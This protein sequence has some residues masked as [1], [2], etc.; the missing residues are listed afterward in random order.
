MTHKLWLVSLQSNLTFLVRKEA[1]VLPIFRWLVA[2]TEF[3][4][5]YFSYFRWAQLA[6]VSFQMKFSYLVRVLVGRMSAKRNRVAE[7]GALERVLSQARKSRTFENRTV[8]QPFVW[9][10]LFQIVYFQDFIQKLVT[11]MDFSIIYGKPHVGHPSGY[12]SGLKTKRLTFLAAWK[13][14]C[15]AGSSFQQN[16]FQT[17]LPL[18][19]Y[20]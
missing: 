18:I 8:N 1:V 19:L 9:N 13:Q 16:E 12:I 2:L 4:I 10:N 15:S 6:F 14:M 3:P 7:R 5:H 17:I 20:Q 11:L